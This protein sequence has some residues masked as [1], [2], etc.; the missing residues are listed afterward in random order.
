MTLT[1]VNVP[2]ADSRGA[3]LCSKLAC[4]L[5]GD[6]MHDREVMGVVGNTADTGKV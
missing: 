2:A 1:N 6:G 4:L 3:V 5:L